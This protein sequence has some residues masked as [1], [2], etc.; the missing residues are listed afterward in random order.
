MELRSRSTTRLPRRWTRARS[1]CSRATRRDRSCSRQPSACCSRTSSGSSSRC[2]ASTCRSRSRRETAN[3][4]VHEAA[5]AI[6]AHGLGLKAA[7]VTPEGRDDVGSPEPDPPRGDRRQGDRA[8]RPS[9]SRR[10]PRRR[11]ARADLRRSHGGRR[12]VRREGV[13]RGRGRRRGRLPHRA[14]RAERLPGGRRVRV[15]TGGADGRQ[16][17]RRAEVHGQPRLRGHA[18]GGDGRRRGAPSRGAVR[19]AAD[20][21]DVRAAHLVERRADGDSR[22]ESRRRHPLRPRPAAVRLDRRLGVPARRVRRRA[23]STSRRR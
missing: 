19:A 23:G 21:R 1:S 16:G 10:P 17:L 20:R 15:P 7:T 5:R 18:E 8:D 2:R 3:G 4:V 11:C 13:A 6:A 22:A 14:H 9:H 12:R